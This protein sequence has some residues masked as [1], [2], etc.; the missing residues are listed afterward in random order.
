MVIT[1][2][3][4]VIIIGPYRSIASSPTLPPEVLTALP[5][6]SP[7]AMSLDTSRASR[8]QTLLVLARG[9]WVSG[10]PGVMNH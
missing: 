8:D 2:T 7:A 9:G 10:P 5:K 4:L 3:N 6:R 1:T